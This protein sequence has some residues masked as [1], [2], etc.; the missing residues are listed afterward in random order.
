MEMK[1]DLGPE[2]TIKSSGMP[3]DPNLTR[4]PIAYVPPKHWIRYSY[5][6]IAPALVEAK[7]AV[8]ALVGSPYQRTWVESLQKIQLKREIAG[9]SRIEG[10]DFTDRELELAIRPEVSAD[11]LLTRSQ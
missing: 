10:A 5:A 1:V 9:T 2:L 3:E 11:E 7:A 6:S 8:L 4:R